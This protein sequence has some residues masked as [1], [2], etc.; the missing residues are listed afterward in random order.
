MFGFGKGAPEAGNTGA[1]RAEPIITAAPQSG[2]IVRRARQRAVMASARAAA[3]NLDAG[4]TDRLS[5]S[6]TATPVTA[7]TVIRNNQRAVVARSR[8]Q[9]LN[10]DYG[11]GFLR[12]VTQ[13]VVG[14]VGIRLQAQ[15]RDQG[16]TLDTE[17]NDAIEQAWRDWCRRENADVTGRRSFVAIQKSAAATAARDGEFM[18]RTIFG[19]EAGPWGFALQVLDPQ[20]CPV[21]YD[22]ERRQD[23]TFIRHG[24]R[25]NR[26]GRP[27]AYLFTTT[28]ER[29]ADYAFGGRSFVTVP[30]SEILHGFVEDMVGQKRGLPWMV[31]A[32]WR[33]RMLAGYEQAA[34]VNARVSA[35]K[36]GFFKWAEGYG[37]ES[38][39]DDASI[40]V[41]VEAG[42][43]QELP[44]GV[45]PV[46]NHPTYP[47]G[48]LAPFRKEMLRGISVGMGV[49]YN[50]LA[51]DLEGVNFS[52]IRQGALDEREHWKGLQEWLIEM[53]VE[54]V[55]LAWLPRALLAGRIKTAAGGTLKPERLEKY[56]SVL[57]QARRWSWI[58]PRADVDAAVTE[59]DNLMRSFGSYI[60]D[61]G[62]DPQTVWREIAQD[63]E[64]MRAAGIPDQF[65]EAALT[66]KGTAPPAPADQADAPAN[67]GDTASG[68]KKGGA[69]NAA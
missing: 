40:E 34:L 26:Y 62:R 35:A 53:L 64:Q 29:D 21:D 27:I 20:R 25:F 66:R 42:V 58:D 31:T 57:W 69:K 45:E 60:R 8:D 19:A 15:A 12:T 54:P 28:D 24:I 17:A 11:R 38:E 7:D 43:W 50:N 59:K 63:V 39:E 41:D 36:G 14:P 48:E 30:A 33:M 22:E 37:P 47:L 46:P 44:A 3:R 6:W 55:F 67:D 16:G 13:N 32:L 52:S 51:N 1:A 61:Q 18:V 68:Q 9:A 5:A 49:A 4:A 65:I 56:R 2:G 23:G 10:N